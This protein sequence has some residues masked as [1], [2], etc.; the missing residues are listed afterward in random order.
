MNIKTCFGISSC[1]GG[2]GKSTIACNIAI[3]LANQGHKVGLLDADIYGPS[4]PTLLGIGDKE[5]E[6]K[7]GKFIPFEIF[8]I[9]AMSIGF[10]VN[11][12]QAIVWRGPMLA[13]GLDGLINKTH[14]G[15]LDYLIVDFPPGTGDVQ[16]SMSQKLKLNG[17][18]IVTTPQLLSLKDVIR[19][20]NMFIKVGV[21]ILGV[22]EN[23][24]YLIDGQEKKFIF[25]ESKTKSW[26]LKENVKLLEE[27][28]F[29]I[30]VPKSCDEGKPYCFDYKDD[31]ALK[32]SNI[33][34][35]ITKKLTVGVIQYAQDVLADNISTNKTHINYIT[36][37]YAE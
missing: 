35:Q 34:D 30:N 7:D 19:G 25:G 24:S 28:P 29:N 11:E 27:L 23:M 6:T 9:K 31:Y 21:P 12:E 16:I 10:L 20:I 26:L 37:I 3:T 4:V 13:K 17:T 36:Y 2:V 8:G 33:T 1:K 14:W 15:D 18:V 32:F 22:V 5:P